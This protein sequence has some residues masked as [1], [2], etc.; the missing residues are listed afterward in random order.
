MEKSSKNWK[1][2]MPNKK[3]YLM[4]REFL[5][6]EIGSS[7]RVLDIGCGEGA[8]GSFLAS[9]LGCSVDGIDLDREKV[10]RAN[11]KLRRS[12]VARLASCNVCD[13]MNIDKKF[14]K[15]TFNSILF[16]HALHHLTDLNSI[17]LKARYLLKHGGNVLI[18]EYRRDYGGKDNCPRF[19]FR[20]IK[21][22]LA[23][24]GFKRIQNYNVHKDLLM[25]KAKVGGKP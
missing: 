20:K 8:I 12:K 9:S 3:P 19:S 22:M 13:S 2:N 24:A 23:T 16:V 11:I 25:I 15:N 6:N 5:K 14:K 17:L 10:Q 18:V 21:S 7:K 1:M 4:I